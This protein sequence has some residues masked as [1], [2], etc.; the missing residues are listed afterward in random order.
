MKKVRKAVIPAAGLGTRFLPATKAQ[1]KEMLPVVDKPAIQYVVEE[2][3]MAGLDDILIVTGRSKRSIEDHFD[4]SF[5]LEYYL[6]QGNKLE[7]LAALREINSMAEIHYVRQGDPK[8]LGH[9]IHAAKAH[10]GNEPF[11]VLLADDI[12]DGR[13]TLLTSML[14][15][16]YRHGRSVLA[17]QHV[18]MSSIHLYGCVVPEPVAD[19][20]VRISSIVEKPR[21]EEAPS[22]LAVTGRYIFTPEIFEAIEATSAGVN[23]EIQLTD[24]VQILL[25][26]QAAYGL[27]T[28]ERRYD[29][30]NKLDYL[31][32]T[33]EIALRRSDLGDAFREVLAEVIAGD[34]DLLGRLGIGE[35]LALTGPSTLRYDGLDSIDDDPSI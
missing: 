10:V 27:I 34:S 24:A 32:A 3:L 13:S 26:W 18:P 1:P 2:A 22:D 4:R 6:E 23:G 19:D 25:G 15:Q 33:I 35:V 30:G 14:N 20:L 8:G 21:T 7:E 16:F 31:R 28:S 11:A 5:E 17:L 29:I 9:A 12:T